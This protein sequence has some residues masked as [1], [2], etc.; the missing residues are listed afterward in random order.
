MTNLQHPRSYNRQCH[1]VIFS[2]LLPIVKSWQDYQNQHVSTFCSILSAI[3]QPYFGETSLNSCQNHILSVL[4]IYLFFFCK[5][6]NQST[7]R[8]K[9]QHSHTKYRSLT[10]K[11]VP[12]LST[13]CGSY[14]G[15]EPVYLTLCYVTSTAFTKSWVYA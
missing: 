12:L 2:R 4:F 7:K 13:P 14:K 9:N 5:G 1:C 6:D 8:D 10:L 15:R 3:F 11:L